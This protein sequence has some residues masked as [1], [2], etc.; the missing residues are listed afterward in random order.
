MKERFS[1]C[2]LELRDSVGELQ[3]PSTREV[4]DQELSPSRRPRGG[5]PCEIRSQKLGMRIAILAGP[6][7]GA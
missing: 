2:R 6:V 1:V 5:E 4:L 7:G 3:F